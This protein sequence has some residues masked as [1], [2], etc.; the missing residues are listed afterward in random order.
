MNKD[1]EVEKIL[2]QTRFNELREDLYKVEERNA[3]GKIDDDEVC[4]RMRTKFQTDING[5]HTELKKV[6]LKLSN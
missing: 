2:L 6:D 1:K 4:K 5:I 3:L